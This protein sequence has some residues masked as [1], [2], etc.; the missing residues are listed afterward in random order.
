MSYLVS[1]TKDIVRDAQIVDTLD[2]P[3]TKYGEIDYEKADWIDFSGEIVL[4]KFEGTNEEAIKKASIQYFIDEKYLVAY[5][6]KEEYIMMDIS[7][8]L[9]AYRMKY[10]ISLNNLATDLGISTHDCSCLC[11]GQKAA[12]EAI[13]DKLVC[14]TNYPKQYWLE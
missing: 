10:H 6:L 8:K 9:S 5:E 14:L 7:K 3:L 1:V 4:G 13:L 2:L 11:T 12:T